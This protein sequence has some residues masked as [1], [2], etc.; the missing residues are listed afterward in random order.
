M[1]FIE[2][3]SPVIRRKN[4]FVLTFL[5]VSLLSYGGTQF[6]P[7]VKKT[8]I[9]FSVKPLSSE[10]E[11]T[12]AFSLDPSESASKIAEMI[13]GWAK[14]PGFRQEILETSQIEISSFKKKLTARKQNRMNVFWTLKLYGKEIK[15]TEKLTQALLAVFE[16]HFK[17]FNENNAAQY[18]ISH[19]SVFKETQ[20]I[21]VSWIV[22]AIV[23]L[24][25]FVSFCGVY[26]Q[27]SLSQT[28]SF[29][30]QVKRV[31]S[32]SSILRISQKLGSHDEKL[33][34]QFILT[35]VSPRFIATFKSANDHFSLASAQDIDFENDTPILLVKLGE[36]TTVELENLKAIYGKKVGVIVFER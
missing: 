16:K 33:L 9:Y 20:V 17:E 15:H 23:F 29:L 10:T 22:V 28:V 32:K 25:F 18:G 11:G 1:N 21:P 36:T 30:T 27:E 34:E 8:T 19:P 13:S 4:Q 35:F 3:L 7:V 6:I 14:N 5:L 12:Q 24:S 26:L 2:F 31:F